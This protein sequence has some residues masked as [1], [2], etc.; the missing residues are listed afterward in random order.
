MADSLASIDIE[1]LDTSKFNV[2]NMSVRAPISLV[3]NASSDSVLQNQAL[4][5]A[6]LYGID[7]AALAAGLSVP[8]EEVYSLQPAMVD[9]PASWVTGEGRDYYNYNP[10]KVAELLEEA[11]YNGEEIVLMYT[12]ST[13]GEEV[14]QII[15]SQL[16]ELGITIKL[17]EV[18]MTVGMDYQYDST[19]WDIR[20][21]TLGGG[22]YMSQVAKSWWSEDSAQHFDNGEIIAMVPDAQADALFVALNENPNDETINAWGDYIQEMAYGYSICSYSN[23]TACVSDYQS[24]LMGNTGWGIVPNAMVKAG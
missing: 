10:E 24:V 1:N 5:Q 2:I 15:Q 11:G 3:L 6:V 4:R 8:A 20:I 13:T 16:R 9:A 23:Q 14:A 21:A 19:K 22:A 18:D 12:T 17:L 7:N